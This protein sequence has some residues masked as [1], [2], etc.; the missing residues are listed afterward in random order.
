MTEPAKSTDHYFLARYESECFSER[1]DVT[2][3]IS[4]D[5]QDEDV[6]MSWRPLFSH[7]LTLRLA[8]LRTLL[9]AAERAMEMTSL[10]ANA[11]ADA[12]LCQFVFRRDGASLLVTRRESKE[13]FYAIS[14][15]PFEQAGDLSN[16]KTEPIQKAITSLEALVDRTRQHVAKS[17][18][19]QK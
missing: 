1:C 15:G 16:L 7:T 4:L 18:E 13:P 19:N 10:L 17:K 8:D 6:T 12:S 2:V 9:Q 3:T 11:P 14:A 5:G